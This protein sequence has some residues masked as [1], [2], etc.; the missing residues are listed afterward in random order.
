MLS[1]NEIIIIRKRRLDARM[2]LKLRSIR[3]I[4]ASEIR[5]LVLVIK[6]RV[7]LVM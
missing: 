6:T 4:S 3:S 5:E 7:S 1:S 2:V